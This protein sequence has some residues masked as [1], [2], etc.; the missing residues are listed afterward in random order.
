MEHKYLSINYLFLFPVYLNSMKKQGQ[1][2][3]GLLDR[4]LRPSRILYFIYMYFSIL[5]RFSPQQITLIYVLF[6]KKI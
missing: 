5:H 3:F 1:E 4:Y 2:G 6:N